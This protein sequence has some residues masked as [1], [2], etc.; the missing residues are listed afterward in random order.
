MLSGPTV[1]G[2]GRTRGGRRLNVTVEL[3]TTGCQALIIK[4][5]IYQDTIIGSNLMLVSSCVIYLYSAVER[6]VRVVS[7]SQTSARVSGVYVTCCLV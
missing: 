5:T 3:N 1:E 2:S 7:Q 6:S 4:T